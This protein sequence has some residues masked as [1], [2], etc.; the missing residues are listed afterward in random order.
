MQTLGPKRRLLHKAQTSARL[1]AHAP[2]MELETTASDQ[3]TYQAIDYAMVNGGRLAKT[4]LF[5][6]H[7]EL[8][9][10]EVAHTE[11][12]TKLGVAAF[13][14]KAFRGQYLRL[15]L[16]ETMT[17]TAYAEKA[18]TLHIDGEAEEYPSGT[19]FTFG[20]HNQTVT[21]ATSR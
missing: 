21:V 14:A 18:I 12:W 3:P 20:P 10:D 1:L 5:K 13:V 11:V 19:Q 16:K 4:W 17:I 8:L 9:E 2:V 6:R 7:L 15:H